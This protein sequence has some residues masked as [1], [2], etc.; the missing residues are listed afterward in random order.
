MK[1]AIVRVC[2][3][4]SLATVLAPSLV[5]AQ[6]E[7]MRRIAY[8]AGG[9][10]SL[11]HEGFEEG[12]RKLGYEPGRN[13]SIEYRWYEG[14]GLERAKQLASEIMQSKPDVIVTAGHPGALAAKEL[15]G[16]IPVVFVGV[17][18]PVRLRLVGSLGR[19]GGTMTGLA[20]DPAPEFVGKG[21]QLFRAAWPKG[22]RLA[23]LRNPDNPMIERYIEASRDAARTLNIEMIDVF[24]RREA[25]I[26]AAFDII[27]TQRMEAV[28]V[29]PDPVTV[30]HHRRIVQRAIQQQLPVLAL[31]REF[32]DAGG[33][34]SYGPSLREHARRAAQYVDKI[35]RGAKPADLPVE[36]PVKFELVINLKAGSALGLAIPQSLRLQAD[37]LLD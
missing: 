14:G 3:A 10:A 26:D 29:F 17:A 18:D 31:M 15:A 19:P 35:L 2:V 34:M 33:L 37:Q 23:L 9:K 5:S 27:R 7:K 20:F 13:V 22:S 11:W 36:Q 1:S 8:L 25:E 12:L 28:F 24:V 30:T 6:S 32:A 16:Q 21:M 4:F